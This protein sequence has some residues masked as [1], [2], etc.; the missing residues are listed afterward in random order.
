MSSSS[1]P[2]AGKS[3]L[4]FVPHNCSLD[5]VFRYNAERIGMQV[6]LLPPHYHIKMSKR[7]RLLHIANKLRG[8]FKEKFKYIAKDREPFYADALRRL[9]E[10]IDYALI[11]RPDLLSPV[12]IRAIKERVSF[13]VGYQWDGMERFPWVKPLIGEFDAFYVFDPKDTVH[14]PQ[15]L[16]TT[17]CCLAV[18]EEPLPSHDPV[19]AEALPPIPSPSSFYEEQKG[20]EAG[21][22]SPPL[23]YYIGCCSSEQRCQT[24]Y[25]FLHYL[26]SQHIPTRAYLYNTRRFDYDF[27]EVGAFTLSRQ[28]S[29]TY[30]QNLRWLQEIDVI[31]DIQNEVHEGFSLRIF[32]SI[33]YRKKLITTNPLVLHED[34]YH[35]NNI[36]V[37]PAEG[38]EG[39]QDFLA[40]PY[41]PLPETIYEKYSFRSWLERLL[42]V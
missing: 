39:L 42:H 3:L 26:Q 13:C 27:S 40:L 33:G 20:E 11:V 24:V 35:P 25:S 4:L 30:D 14:Y 12:T 21:P 32:E 22:S 41:A 5:E 10:R 16:L 6:F 23:C 1:S 19:P 7:H 36:F 15:T 9:P 2:L 28:Q 17:N 37:L 29:I 38:Y 34:F 8:R 18:P 31:I